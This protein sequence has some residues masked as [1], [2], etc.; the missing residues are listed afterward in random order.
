MKKGIW[1]LFA[2]VAVIV[3]ACFV[4]RLDY[5]DEVLY[6]MSEGTYEVLREKL[7]DVST[8]KLVDVYV[9]DCEY[10]DSLGRLK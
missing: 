1:H 9:S 6:H 3:A 10:W 4:G 5:N 8:T 7:G 2:L